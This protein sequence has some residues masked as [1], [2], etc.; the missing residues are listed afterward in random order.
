MSGGKTSNSCDGTTG[1]TV[2]NIGGHAKGAVNTRSVN[3]DNN[4]TSTGGG[5]SIELPF[6]VTVPVPALQ[7]LFMDGF[8]SDME[9]MG[10]DIK[11]FF[12][13][14]HHNATMVAPHVYVM[15][16]DNKKH[17][18]VLVHTDS[19]QNLATDMQL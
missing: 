1:L 12:T 9:S 19:L 18:V 15:D 5:V 7:N 8:V 4:G 10:D 11:G 3:C 14:H 13:G 16:G 6:D 2:G 17:S